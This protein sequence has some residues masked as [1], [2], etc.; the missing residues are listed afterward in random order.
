MPSFFF[1]WDKWP[2]ERLSDFQVFLCW[3]GGAWSH[4]WQRRYF[5]V[6][7]LW[8]VC[9]G[10]RAYGVFFH[11]EITWHNGK[12]MECAVKQMWVPFMPLILPRCLSGSWFSWVLV[13]PQKKMQL[14][15]ALL[16][17]VCRIWN[18]TQS[19]DELDQS[20]LFLSLS[21]SLPNLCF[22]QAV[23]HWW[24]LLMASTRGKAAP[25]ASEREGFSLVCEHHRWKRKEQKKGRQAFQAGM[26]ELEEG[27]VG[28]KSKKIV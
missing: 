21:F 12:C 1:K 23:S 16:P 14:T 9:L 5:F 11:L 20:E 18:A 24:G 27:F 8:T 13:A 26:Q 7:F 6:T 15:R 10:M 17:S 22:V 19:Q 2:L 3:G 25:W 4:T 28:D